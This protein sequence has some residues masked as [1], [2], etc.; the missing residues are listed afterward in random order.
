[1]V[2]ILNILISWVLNFEWP[3]LRWQGTFARTK[4]PNLPSDGYAT[5]KEDLEIESLLF[6]DGISNPDTS[7]SNRMFNSYFS[8]QPAKQENY[9]SSSAFCTPSQVVRS[10][11]NTF[12]KQVLSGMLE[13]VTPD[14][15]KPEERCRRASLQNSQPEVKGKC[16]VHTTAKENSKVGSNQLDHV[17]STSV[18]DLIT[19]ST[20]HSQVTAFLWAVC[21]SLIPKEF[22]GSTLYWRRLYSS[23]ACFV[24]LRRHEAFSIQHILT[25]LRLSGCTWLKGGQPA[26]DIQSPHKL[27]NFHVGR[28]LSSRVK[29]EDAVT[30]LQLIGMQQLMLE[31]WLFWMFSNLIVPLIKSHFYVTESENRRQNVFYYRKPVWA[32][33]QLLSLRELTSRC[34]TK[35][36]RS[37]VAAALQKRSL[38]FSRIRLLPKQNGVRPISNLSAASK[39]AL[40]SIERS[41]DGNSKATSE[42]YRY[43]CRSVGNFGGDCSLNL[44][45]S[46]H[47]RHALKYGKNQVKFAFKSINS[48]LKDTH[49]CLKY[50]QEHHSE[51]LGSSV[52]GYKDAYVKLLPFILHLK[53][54]QSGLPPL[55]MAVCDISRAYD[56]IQQEKL[57]EV[58]CAFLRLPVYVVLRYS[59]VFQT[60]GSL[61]VAYKRACTDSCQPLELFNSL[62]DATAKHSHSVLQDQVH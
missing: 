39:C 36:D 27:R 2:N 55:Y 19:C 11:D 21:R 17:E 48:V 37:S 8:K 6:S 1:M 46:I 16:Q 24:G 25:K 44:P 5:Q 18:S 15:L 14:A 60:M 12:S 9:D 26:G 30:S 58:V 10:H 47:S 53:N 61:R 28:N 3:S 51:D 23:I 13:A 40:P 32:K 62:S 52:F 56:T 50:E 4:L 33:I 54:S 41:R 43:S 22:L 45:Q 29:T 57:F 31:D 7:G 59:S 49:V 35:L 42:S 34:Y 20:G 38:G